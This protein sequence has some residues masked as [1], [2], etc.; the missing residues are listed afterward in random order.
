MD[1]F[2]GKFTEFSKEL[3]E[4]TESNMNHK[5]REKKYKRMINQLEV[6]NLELEEKFKYA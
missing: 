6:R 4:L 2:D 5:E 3:T 1:K